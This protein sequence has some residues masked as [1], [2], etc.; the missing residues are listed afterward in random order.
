MYGETDVCTFPKSLRGSG[1]AEAMTYDYDKYD[2]AKAI[3]QTVSE[4]AVANDVTLNS[5]P[6]FDNDALIDRT[7][8]SGHAEESDDSSHSTTN[9]AERPLLN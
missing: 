5:A 2:N 6:V 3:E 1:G 7:E 8:D 4:A 9:S